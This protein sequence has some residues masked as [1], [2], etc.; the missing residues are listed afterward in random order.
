MFPIQ[1]KGLNPVE[2]V[3]AWQ[4]SVRGTSASLLLSTE[5]SCCHSLEDGLAQEQDVLTDFTKED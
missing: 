2:A 5:A 1:L 4:R 3:T